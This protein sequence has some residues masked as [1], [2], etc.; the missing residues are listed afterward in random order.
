MLYHDYRMNLQIILT[1][2]FHQRN[3]SIA[4]H[5]QYGYC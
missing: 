1:A 5:G 3:Q 4:T 2:F